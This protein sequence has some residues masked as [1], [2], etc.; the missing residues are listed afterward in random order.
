MPPDSSRTIMKQSALPGKGSGADCSN[1]TT[2]H[3]PAE[4]DDA[5]LAR[6]D[7]SDLVARDIREN[8]EYRHIHLAGAC[9]TFLEG[10]HV[11]AQLL[12]RDFVKGTIG[13]EA[14]GQRLGKSP[15]S[16]MRMLSAKG[17]PRAD[18]LAAIIAALAEHS[19]LR[20]VVRA[21]PASGD[22]HS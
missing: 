20:L 11:T 5:R 19:G 18:N 3:Q 17:N 8:V 1:P 15:K 6:H 12:L 2:T 16:L 21:E 13:F 9:E 22:S 7:F 14:L 4:I 10:D